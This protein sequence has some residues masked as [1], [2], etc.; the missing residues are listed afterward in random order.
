LKQVES[1]DSEPIIL[2]ALIFKY[3]FDFGSEDSIEFHSSLNNTKNTEVFK[4][5][6]I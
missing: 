4:A 1:N 3:N 2:K 5:E 6:A